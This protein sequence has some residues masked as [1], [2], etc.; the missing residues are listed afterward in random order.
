MPKRSRSSSLVRKVTIPPTIS[1]SSSVFPAVPANLKRYIAKAIKKSVEKKSVSLD[2]GLVNFNSVVNS[3]GDMINLM[4]PVP[5]GLGDGDR[6]GDQLQGDSVELNGHIQAT[7]GLTRFTGS[8]ECRLAV[9]VFV[10]QAALSGNVSVL[11]TMNGNTGDLFNN[12]LKKG[13]QCGPFAGDVQSLYLPVNQAVYKVY[14][15][16]VH[17][18]TV[19]WQRNAATIG[20]QQVNDSVDL[21]K[22]FKMIKI[23]IPCKKMMQYQNSGSNVP[24]NFAP[25]MYI[26]YSHV[27]GTAADVVDT[28]IQAQF[29]STFNYTDN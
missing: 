28:K 9:R 19:P 17:F 14:Y 27:D 20:V 21:A 23:K 22:S 25:F 16:K 18:I 29:V 6:I 1:R 3:G 15:D 8:G 24:V 26:G 13:D 7:L 12:L 4:P 5:Q 2:T 10:L 11:T